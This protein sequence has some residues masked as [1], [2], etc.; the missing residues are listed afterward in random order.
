MAPLDPLPDTIVQT[1]LALHR[2]ATYVIAPIRYRSTERFGLRATSGGFGTPQFGDRR[3]RVE[4]IEII[5][6]QDGNERRAPISSLSAAADFLGAEV[7]PDTAAEHDS[8]PLGDIAE[9]LNVDLAASDWLG[10]WFGTAFEALTLVSGDA[11]SVHASEPQLW[12]GHFDPAIEM[13]DE[14]HRA[15]YGA[16]P[17]DDSIAEPYLYVSVW[18][19]DRLG[20]GRDE[21]WNAQPFVGR[22]LLLRDFAKGIAPIAVAADFW[23]ET[24]DFLDRQQAPT[25]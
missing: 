25:T 13:G 22:Q 23:R 24:R 11:A 15:S 1:R 9:N 6:E 19:P 17:G 5:D 4:G 3:I 7:D 8:P 20:I 10:R 16:S 2:L 21:T 14:N 18:W 12:P